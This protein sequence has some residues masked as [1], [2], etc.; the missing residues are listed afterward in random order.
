METTITYSET[1]IGNTTYKVE[2]IYLG[3][4]EF[5][6]AIEKLIVQK[7]LTQTVNQ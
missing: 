2:S 4:I 5:S 1:K 7:A 3:N 6:K